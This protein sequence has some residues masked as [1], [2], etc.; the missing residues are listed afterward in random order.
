MAVESK[1]HA[2]R[3]SWR[4]AVGFSVW[5]LLIIAGL[6]G[7]FA[8]CHGEALIV[9]GGANFTSAA[10]S[11]DLRWTS[12]FALSRPLAYGACASTSAGVVCV[13]GNDADRV[14][15]DAFVLSWRPETAALAQTLLP[16]LPV[17]STAGAAALIGGHVYLVSGQAGLD[18]ATATDHVW[19][20]DLAAACR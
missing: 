20:L 19:R 7:P 11:S 14:F 8:G 9:A 3:T 15:A 13:G 17:P 10:S 4:R 18:L 1:S 6:G 2:H 16:P 5:V 12:G